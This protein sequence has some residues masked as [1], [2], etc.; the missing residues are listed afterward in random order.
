MNFVSKK[1]SELCEDEW[2]ERT[3]R[4]HQQKHGVDSKNPDANPD[5]YK[6]GM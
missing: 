6:P 1:I 4:L 3:R 5:G 2:A